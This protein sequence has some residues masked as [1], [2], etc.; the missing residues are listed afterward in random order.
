[1]REDG[2]YPSGNKVKDFF[3]KNK[4]L[5]IILGSSLLFML[6]TII[7]CCCCCC[8]GGRKD[9]YIYKTYSQVGGGLADIEQ[10]DDDTPKDGAI[11]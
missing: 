7:I 4:M 2:D 8:K 6:I 11:N 9:T 5:T 3:N 1:M 10:L